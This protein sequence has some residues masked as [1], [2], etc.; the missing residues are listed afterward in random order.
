VR[1]KTMAFRADVFEDIES[2]DTGVITPVVLLT[3][4]E[5]TTENG[6]E[7]E[8]EVEFWKDQTLTQARDK[9]TGDILEKMLVLSK[10]FHDDFHELSKQMSAVK[11]VKE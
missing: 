2:D 9:A 4:M 5:I 3:L 1:A 6:V 7:S 10:K 8:G 11:A